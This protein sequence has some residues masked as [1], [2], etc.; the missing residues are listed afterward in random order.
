MG[1]DIFVDAL[2]L[3]PIGLSWCYG[4]KAGEDV[5]GP[6][7]EQQVVVGV[8]ERAPIGFSTL[9]SQKWNDQPP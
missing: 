3:A 1:Q 4:Q 7:A 9:S 5:V 6:L 8:D 2:E